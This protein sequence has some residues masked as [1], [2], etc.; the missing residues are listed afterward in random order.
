MDPEDEIDAG[1]ETAFAEAMGLPVDDLQTPPEPELTGTELEEPVVAAV[2]EGE[3]VVE[4]VETPVVEP[5]AAPVVET[6]PVEPVAAASQAPL[7]PKFIAQAVLEAQ[8]QQRLAGV[9]QAAAD[10]AKADAEKVF[11]ADDFIDDEGR[12]ALALLNSEWSEVA[13]PVQ[14]LIQASVQAALQNQRRDI[15]GEVN[16]RMAPIQQITAQSQEAVFNATVS[17][18]HPDWRELASLLPEWIEDQPMKQAKEYLKAFNSGDVA[19][20]V[21]LLTAYKQAKGLTG[22]APAQPASSAAPGTPPVVKPA[23][24]SKAALAATAAVPAAQRST[25]V[26][27]ADPNDF[28]AGFAEAMAATR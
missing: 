27:S 11:T 7:D 19:G 21:Q 23:P 17:A 2:T 14:I 3:P 15:L 13:G 16:T 12:K 24:V 20:S 18:V 25:P 28:E 10:K 8:E 5:A 9:Q 4:T 22:A 6:A 1:F 26:N